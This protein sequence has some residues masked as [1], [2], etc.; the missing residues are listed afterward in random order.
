MSGLQE[1]KKTV[2]VPRGMGIDGMVALFKHIVSLS[3]VQYIHVD[4]QGRITY[5]RFVREDEK[6][7]EYELSEEFKGML[8]SAILQY[9]DLREI[10]EDSNAG[11]AIGR[12]IYGVTSDGLVP[13]AFALHP[14]SLFWKWHVASV[15]FDISSKSESIYGVPTRFDEM[16][17]DTSLVIMAGYKHD[18]PLS[19]TRRALKIVIPVTG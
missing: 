7:D 4:G 14:K 16:I 11:R 19:D 15:G 9:V 13:L 17:P 18:A 1:R 6:E 2:V 3:R 10:D 8:P 5:A 12:L